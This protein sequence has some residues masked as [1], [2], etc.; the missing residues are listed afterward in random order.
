MSHALIQ[1]DR[2]AILAAVLV[3]ESHR[4]GGSVELYGSSDPMGDP[5]VY[6]SLEVEPTSYH[7]SIRIDGA[8]RQATFALRRA[9]LDWLRRAVDD[10]WSPESAR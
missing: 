10:H 3:V 1:V 8:L 5:V 9:A 7:V 6:L 4:M 2:A